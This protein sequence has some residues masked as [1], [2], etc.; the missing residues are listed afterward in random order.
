MKLGARMI[1]TGISVTLTLY[2]ALLFEMEPIVYAAV[3]AV[4]STQPSLYRSWQNM[5][6]QLHA[7]LIGAVLAVTFTY[8]LGNDPFIVGLVVILVIAI[9]IQL[10]IEKSISLAIVTVIAIME[11]TTG[12]FFLFALDRFLLILLGMGSAFV[13]NILFMPPRYEDRLYNGIN[14][15]NQEILP[16]LR[17]TALN[18]LDDKTLRQDLKR[19]EEELAELD[20]LY[21]LFK[22]ERSYFSKVKYSKIRKLVI[23]R[24]MIQ[25]LTKALALLRHVEEHQTELQ[26]LPLQ[27]KE[28][29]RQTIDQLASYTSRILLKYEG[30]LKAN[31]LHQASDYEQDR[32]RLIANFLHIYQHQQTD[33]EEEWQDVFPIISLI[34][35]YSTRLEHLE[36]LIRS[37]YSFHQK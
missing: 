35:D 14:Q 27:L 22:E 3:A 20:Q 7:N 15:L 1:K 10:K 23:F 30:K 21:M 11:S 34:I 28:I 6:D 9:T 2:L 4:L 31:H 25:T 33:N 24:Q 5:I 36:K 29:I 37:Y 19:F 18:E 12:N 16:Y 13:V 8:F 17:A 32:K 26:R